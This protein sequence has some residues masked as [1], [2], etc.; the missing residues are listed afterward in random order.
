LALWPQ[1]S[2]VMCLPAQIGDYTDF[3]S[4]RVHATNVGIMFRDPAN[5]LLPNWLHLPVGYHGRSSSV[6][7]SGTPVRRP[8]GQIKADDKEPPAWDTSKNLDFE[9]EMAFFVGPGNEMGTSIPI[10]EAEDHIFGIVIMNDWSARDIQKWEYVPL[11]PFLAKSMA[12]TISPWVV[13][14]D[15]LEPFRLAAPL[16]PQV[17]PVPLPYL[18]D[19]NAAFYDVKLEVTLKSAKMAEPQVICES[20]MKHLYWSMKQQLT[21]HASNGCPMRP[22]DLCGSGTISGP[23][24]TEFG[25]MLE[26]CW[27]GTKPMKLSSG[28][29]RKFLANGDTVCMRAYCEGPGYRIGFG[30]CEGTVLPALT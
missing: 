29:E 24:P 15:A 12:T 4:S 10:A 8:C 3:Y 30:K 17:D 6:V 7:V 14:L 28:E 23:E 20:N 22:G 25:S 19:P 21:H 1:A 13:P 9:L 26:L 2:S 18:R 27:K 5:A 16:Y 11:G